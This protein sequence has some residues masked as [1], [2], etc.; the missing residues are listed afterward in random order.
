MWGGYFASN[1]TAAALN[2]GYVDYAVRGQGEQTLLELIEAI[3]NKRDLKDIPG[4]SYKTADGMVRNNPERRM[5]GLDDFPT[6]PYHR[7]PTE[8]YLLPTFLGRRTAVHQASLGCP[9]GCNF[10]GVVGFSGS[11]Q[12]MESPERTAGVLRHLVETYGADAV[13]FYD[14]NF[15]RAKI[16]RANWQTGWPRSIF[17]GDLGR[18]AF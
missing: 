1:Y 4:L 7:I 16:T 11:R 13:Q 3:R 18:L 10:C 17:A 12:R 14:N 5:R 8:R 15:F 6:Y 9:Y 2:A